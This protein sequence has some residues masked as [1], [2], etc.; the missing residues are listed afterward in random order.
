MKYPETLGVIINPQAGQGFSE[1]AWVAREVLSR[2]PNSKILTGPGELGAAAFTDHPSRIDICECDTKSGRMQSVTLA[3]NLAARKV[4]LLLVIGGDGTLSDTAFGLIETNTRPPVMGIGV[5]STNVGPLVA[6]F[7]RE[8]G[9]IQ[10]SLLDT[11]SLPAILVKHEGSLLGI[12]F[13]DCVIG[14]TV[15]GMIDGKACDVDVASKL[16]GVNIAGCPRSIGTATSKVERLWADQVTEVGCGEW[17]AGVVI[18]IA[19]RAFLGKAITGGICLAA[20][21]GA[22][23]GCLLSSVPLVQVSINRV[24]VVKKEPITTRYICLDETAEIRVQ[25]IREG[26]AVN[27]DGTPLKILSTADQI[28]LSIIPNAIQAVHIG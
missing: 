16:I 8:V 22:L 4:D 21:T 13:N 2:F 11:V 25:G 12:G 19:E 5:G 24:D 10:P 20:Y 17:I 6:C 15:V 28:R 18:G 9:K 1:N 14:F 3:R 27:A 23:A 26:A 7:G